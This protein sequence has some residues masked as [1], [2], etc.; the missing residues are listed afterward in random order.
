MSNMKIKA[1][2]TVFAL[3]ALLSSC[4]MTKVI[5]E[6]KSLLSA[7][8][9]VFNG[10][11]P[12]ELSDLSKYIKQTP[13][14]GIF[15]YQFSV[16]LYNTG[17]GTGKGWD[18]IAEKMGTPPL[19][20]DEDL[21]ES[22]VKNMLNHMKFKGFYDSKIT[23]SV[24]TEKKRTK[25]TYTVTPGKRYIIDTVTYTIP[26][27]DMYDIMSANRK[28]SL[29]KVG[30]WLSEDILE[31]ESERVAEIF[32][33]SGYFGF[34]KG[35]L[36][37]TGDTLEHNGKSHLD[38]AIRDYLRSGSEKD[39]RPHKVFTF[40]DVLVSTRR[41]FQQN[42][43]IRISPDSSIVARRDSLLTVWRNQIDTIKYGN[44]KVISYSQSANLVRGKVLNRLNLIQPGE[45]YD[46][47]IVEATYSR[48]S[49][50]N[51]FS[52]VNIQQ[53]EI[54]SSKVLTSIVLQASSVQGFKVDLQGSTNANGL[55]GISPAI[56]YFHKNVFRGAELLTVGLMGDF[57][58]KLHN[59][60]H[61][62]EIGLNTT[63][64]I[65]RFLFAPHTWFRSRTIPHTEIGLSYSYQ[66]RPE[67]TRNILSASFN[68]NWNIKR[69][70]YWKVTP[71]QAN[72]VR[73]FNLDSTFYKKLSD[74]Y[75]KNSYSDHFDLGVG[76]S[77]YYVSDPATKPVHDF[78]YI[79]YGLDLSGNLL[80]LFNSQ[81][82][83]NDRGERLVW[84][85]PY[86]QYFRMELSGVY[87]F[88]FGGNPNHM[89]AF[90][91]LGG[92]GKGYGNS[93]M[94]PLEKM[95]WGGGAYDMRGWQPR[96]LG[97][98]Y[99]PRDSAFRIPNQT[100]DIKLE[101]NMEYRF[102][103]IS[104]VNGAVFS[105]LG[106]I[107]TFDRKN[108]A[109]GEEAD[110]RGVFRSSD[111]Y[112]HLALD[113]GLGLRVDLDFAVIRLDL[114]FKTY[115]PASSEWIG[116]DKWLKKDNFEISF[117]IGYPF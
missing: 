102:P 80:S 20:F 28:E 82:K 8:E 17:K 106:N 39:A 103:I 104:V 115:N 75:L 65:P 2:I 68:Y 53:Q 47:D 97:P 9:I 13:K 89:L 72:I 92:V 3:C 29:V 27:V 117:G 101:A 81:M 61:S 38:I 5:P 15:G 88:K 111:F 34:D 108:K 7:N 35:F 77:F 10:K 66:T 93:T 112:K 90:R 43:P 49:S 6:D 85:S 83:K 78:W 55:L 4:S 60:V 40:S 79:R 74:P 41:N 71:V 96:T 114:G 30:D 113:W 57:Q 54:D 59:N 26:D 73:I 62:T 84:K 45:Q 76:A 107:W 69:K 46:E 22:S 48:F 116:P 16:A 32:R 52:S 87:T 67:Y 1:L 12:E 100:G 109:T 31:Q 64:D 50:L 110:K 99:A 44:I 37:F 11:Q 23:S 24:N 94:L 33:N 95:F 98:G 18:K 58:F 91:A 25:V 70:Y 56:S 42:R 51:L 21:V 86:S 14:K 36:F 63:L 105:D 19:I